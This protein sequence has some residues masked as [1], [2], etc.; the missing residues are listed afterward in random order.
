MLYR[1]VFPLC[2]H[3]FRDDGEIQAYNFSKPNN[4]S[5]IITRSN[6]SMCDVNKCIRKCCQ[7][8]EIFSEMKCRKDEKRDTFN[9]YMK[10]YGFELENS[11]KILY[12]ELQCDV[13]NN[14][15]KIQL[16]NFHLYENGS[17]YVEDA[18]DI[19]SLENY[20]LE[21]ASKND[22]DIVVVFVCGPSTELLDLV[23]KPEGIHIGKERYSSVFNCTFNKTHIN[24]L[25]NLISDKQIF[26][27]KIEATSSRKY[28][29]REQIGKLL[30]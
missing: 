23:T 28:T 10:N 27:I 18:N 2:V 16:E 7:K 8:N 11:S 3:Y 30:L 1:E 29:N 20:C 19:F 13:K 6:G 12:S 22:G 21:T 9:V 5:N 14:F 4:L 26:L 24:A 15:Y 17:V 25:S